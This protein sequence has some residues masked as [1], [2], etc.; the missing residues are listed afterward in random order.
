MKAAAVFAAS[1]LLLA[2]CAGEPEA[3]TSPTTVSEIT[4]NTDLQSIGNAGSVRY[5]QTLDEDLEAALV[6]EFLGRIDPAGAVI[7]VDVD[8]ISLA[9]AF[10]SRF[11]GEDSRLSGR[12]TVTDRVTGEPLGTYDVTATS[13]EA[14][15][16]LAGE[17]V[18]S[19][20]PDSGEF[21]AAVVQAFAR[22]VVQSVL[23]GA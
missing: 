3:P 5:W 17:G 23:Q 12:V 11:Q 15:N 18:T 20:S 19:I 21:Y 1:A 7:A 10:T 8:E 13:R 9:N 16:L 6:T 22:G 14:Q 2:A 4:V